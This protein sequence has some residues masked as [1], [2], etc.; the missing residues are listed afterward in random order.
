MG[1][2]RLLIIIN[3]MPCRF[4]GPFTNTPPPTLLLLS[5][6]SILILPR[7]TNATAEHAFLLLFFPCSNLLLSKTY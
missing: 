5:F 1:R 4:C 6:H 7:A 2:D 3:A